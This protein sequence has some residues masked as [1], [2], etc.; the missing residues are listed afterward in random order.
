MGGT[1]DKFSDHIPEEVI[2]N[3][4]N[5]AK[6]LEVLEGMNQA[7]RRQLDVYTR[8]FLYPLVFDIGLLR[9]Y[10]DEWNAEYTSRS[11]NKCL[12]CLYR[13]YNA[14]YSAKGTEKGLIQLLK[15][16]M[17][18]VDEP[19]IEITGYI[20]WKPLIL[21]D[22]NS[23]YD[24]LPE[25]QDIADERLAELG[26]EIWCPKLLDT[27]WLHQRTVITID[28]TAGYVPNEDFLIFIRSVIILYLPMANPDLTD[29]ELNIL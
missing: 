2:K 11:T 3:N 29:V 24:V 15:C 25:G 26:E 17:W 7:R 13:N 22:D 16:L 1:I 20:G 27:T 21:F 5:L 6:L 28:I 12:D 10:V 9:R 14:I 18:V 4:P 19:I 23:A 8:R